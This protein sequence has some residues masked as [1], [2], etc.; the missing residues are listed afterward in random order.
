MASP[1]SG[2]RKSP[3]LQELEDIFSEKTRRFSPF[4]VLG[5]KTPAETEAESESDTT[6]D[7]SDITYVRSDTTQD[8]PDMPEGMSDLTRDTKVVE[9]NNTTTEETEVSDTT[10][11]MPDMTHVRSDTRDVIAEKQAASPLGMHE[12]LEATHQRG[13]LSVKDRQVLRYLNGLRQLDNPAYTVAVG[14]GQV[15]AQTNVHI[16]HIR[17]N[18]L[19]KLAMLGLIGVARKSYE[20]T[21]YHLPRSVSFVEAVASEEVDTPL[22]HIS[23]VPEVSASPP[24]EDAHSQTLPPWVDREQWS[25]LAP[26]VVRQLVLRAGSEAQA[27]EVLDIIVYNETHGPEEQR[28]R[29]RRAVLSHYLRNAEAEIWPNDKDFET[30][31]ERQA[32]ERRD[33]ERRVKALADEARALAEETLRVQQET[34]RLRFLAELSE[35]QRAWLKQEAKRRV[36]AE[37][38]AKLLESRYPL[39]KAKEE[40]LIEE[41]LDRSSF[42]E[43]VP[44]EDGSDENPEETD[45]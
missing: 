6:H 27:R 35:A 17:R 38:G 24:Q 28:V 8:M 34:A 10:Y 9:V 18:V 41:W 5:L 13:K 2:K 12:L 16:N 20:G 7:M 22:A 29:N 45:R 42:G 43:A 14:Y 21:V 11:D 23:G 1:R 33:K 36:D 37:P 32:R 40:E 44:E 30:L 19:P 39:Y 26:E 15:S 4:R 3:H 31:A 25:W